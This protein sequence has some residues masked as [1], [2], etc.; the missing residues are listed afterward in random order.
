LRVDGRIVPHSRER[1]QQ[2]GLVLN[3]FQ[4]LGHVERHGGS[5]FRFKVAVCTRL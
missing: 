4:F 3:L 5:P 1:S 2:Q